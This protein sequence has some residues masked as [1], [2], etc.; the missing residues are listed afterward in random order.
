MKLKNGANKVMIWRNQADVTLVL[1]Q[2]GAEVYRQTLDIDPRTASEEIWAAA[3]Q[4][5]NQIGQWA[6]QAAAQPPVLQPLMVRDAASEVAAPCRVL[7]PFGLKGEYRL[8]VTSN[9]YPLPERARQ[10]RLCRLAD[11][12]AFCARI[13]RT[14][15]RPVSPV[16]LHPAA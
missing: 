14:R 6:R 15:S 11:E 1:A 5:L 2:G 12:I 9:L 10:D 8:E 16:S 3:A 13:A 7:V 4:H